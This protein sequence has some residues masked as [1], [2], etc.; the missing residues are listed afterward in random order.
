[1]IE[2]TNNNIRKIVAAQLAENLG[3]TVEALEKPDNKTVVCSPVGDESYHFC[4]ITCYRNTVIASVDE[5]IKEFTEQFIADRIGFRCFEEINLLSDEFRKHNKKIG[6]RTEAFIPDVT[7]INPSKA[8]FD[9]VILQGEEISALYDDKRFHMA[10][11]YETTGTNADMLAVVG[12]A[13]GQI[14][15]VAGASND[16]ETMW[17]VGIDVLPEYRNKGVATI[18]TTILTNEILKRGIVPFYQCAWSHIASKNTAINSG[19]KSAWV[20][21]CADE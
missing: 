8:D 9:I 10:L 3:C 17:Q 16:Y 7:R 5:Q 11:S 21:I 18:L 6:I 2:L 20:T 19:Y 13:D 14:M 4:E 12:Y 1:M 15:G